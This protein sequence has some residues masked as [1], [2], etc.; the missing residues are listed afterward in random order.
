MN[1]LERQAIAQHVEEIS[2]KLA[3]LRDS[4]AEARKSGV[5]YHGEYPGAVM[6]ELN[7]IRRDMSDGIASI[8]G[9]E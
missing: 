1:Q 3:S 8:L 5:A 7:A 2:H 9:G 4:I 6:G